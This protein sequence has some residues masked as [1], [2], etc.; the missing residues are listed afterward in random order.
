MLT[1]SG[2]SSIREF[3]NRIFEWR[4]SVATQKGNETEDSSYLQEQKSV[5]VRARIR[6]EVQLKQNEIPIRVIVARRGTRSIAPSSKVIGIL[7]IS[8]QPSS[9]PVLDAEFNLPHG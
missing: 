5:S 8:I 4:P 7:D 9:L 6:R 3:N 2:I 1:N